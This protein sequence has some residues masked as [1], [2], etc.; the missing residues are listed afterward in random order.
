LDQDSGILR[1]LKR[2]IARGR[3]V[4]LLGT[5]V[6]AAS[7]GNHPLTNWRCLLQSGITRCTSFGAGN[8]RQD[9]EQRQHSALLGDLIDVLGVAQ[10]VESRLRAAG[11]EFA[12]WLRETIGSIRLENSLVLT[13]IEKI[14]APIATTNYDLLIEQALNRSSLV[15]ADGVDITHWLTH[16]NSQVPCSI[17]TEFGDAQKL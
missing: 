12:T 1:E 11:A 4:V 6:S 8:V 2:D 14:D 15:L 16:L 7:A 17:F 3:I 5:G 10:Q 13:A 9:W